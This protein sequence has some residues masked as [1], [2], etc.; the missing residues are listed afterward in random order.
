MNPKHCEK[1]KSD[2]RVLDIRHKG[3]DHLSRRREC[4]GCGF[5]WTT[6]EI[7]AEVHRWLVAY[8][9]LPDVLEQ[10]NEAITRAE[11]VRLLLKNRR[12]T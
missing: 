7:P 3:L 1:C 11:R 12:K 4:K 10:L 8:Q 6:C 2:S 9:D 5:R